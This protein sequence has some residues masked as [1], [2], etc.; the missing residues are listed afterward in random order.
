VIKEACRECGGDGVVKEKAEIPVDIPAGIDSETRIRIA[1]EGEP[2]MSGGPRGD[3][4][5]DVTVR[6]HPVFEREGNDLLCDLP[7]SFVQAA[8]G[9]ELELPNLL[10]EKVTLKVPRGTPGGQRL[11]VRGH[12][13]P[14]VNTGRRGD[15]IVRLMIEVPKSLTKAQEELLR[16]YAKSEKIEVKPKKKGFFDKLKDIFEP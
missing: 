14:D 12:G 16:E 15:M 10:D 4:Y 9:A 13:M 3:L 6:P 1:G 8:L 5:V 11:R 7:I 2:S